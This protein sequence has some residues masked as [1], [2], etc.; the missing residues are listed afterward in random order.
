[1]QHRENIGQHSQQ[2]IPQIQLGTDEFSRDFHLNVWRESHER[3]A[4]EWNPSVRGLN[5][6]VRGLNP[7]VRRLDYPTHL[8]LT[9]SHNVDGTVARYRSLSTSA[10]EQPSLAFRGERGHSLSHPRANPQ[11]HPG[12]SNP[13]PRD[14]RRYSTGHLGSTYNGDSTTGLQ[15]F[16]EVCTYGNYRP[17][18]QSAGGTNAQGLTKLSNTADEYNPVVRNATEAR[19]PQVLNSGHIRT[20][21]YGNEDYNPVVRNAEGTN[22]EVLNAGD[23]QTSTYTTNTSED[24]N[25]VVRGIEGRNL[26]V[27][28]GDNIRK[29]SSLSS[30]TESQVKSIE[31]RRRRAKRQHPPTVVV[32]SDSD[33]EELK[34]LSPLSSDDYDQDVFTVDPSRGSLS[35]NSPN[36]STSES[37]AACIITKVKDPGDKSV[38]LIGKD[39]GVSC[40]SQKDTGPSKTGQES[41]EYDVNNNESRE[42]VERNYQQSREGMG[43][44]HEQCR[45]GNGYRSVL[46]EREIAGQSGTQRVVMSEQ[47][48]FD[49]DKRGTKRTVKDKAQYF[50]AGSAE[51]A[52]SSFDHTAS[53][54]RRISTNDLEECKRRRSDTMDNASHQSSQYNRAN[55]NSGETPKPTRNYEDMP[56]LIRSRSENDEQIAKQML[57]NERS[58]SLTY[59]SR[60]FESKMDDS[61]IKTDVIEQIK[62]YKLSSKNETKSHCK[63]CLDGSICIVRVPEVVTVTKAG[64]V[65]SR[66]EI[67]CRNCDRVL[68]QY[69]SPG[70][71]I[72][73]TAVKLPRSGPKPTGVVV[74]IKQEPEVKQP[75]E[76]ETVGSEN[77]LKKPLQSKVVGLEKELEQL[78]E[79]NTV[80]SEK[81]VKNSGPKFVIHEEDDFIYEDKVSSDK[82]SDDLD[83][84]HFSVVKKDAGV[85]WTNSK[86]HAKNTASLR[87][88]VHPSQQWEAFSLKLEQEQMIKNSC[89]QK[90]FNIKRNSWEELR[91]KFAAEEKMFS[92]GIQH[93]SVACSDISERS[94]A[95]RKRA[96]SCENVPESSHYY[97]S[98]KFHDATEKLSE[99]FKQR[100]VSEKCGSEILASSNLPDRVSESEALASGN[101]AS[102]EE[103]NTATQTQAITT[104]SSYFFTKANTSEVLTTSNSTSIGKDLITVNC[105]TQTALTQGTADNVLKTTTKP[106]A[107]LPKDSGLSHLTKGSRDYHCVEISKSPKKVASAVMNIVGEISNVDSTETV[108]SKAQ[109]FSPSDKKPYEIRLSE[110][111]PIELNTRKFEANTG[112]K[113]PYEIRSSDIRPSEE[114]PFEIHTHGKDP[115]QIRPSDKRPFEVEPA[116]P[117]KETKAPESPQKELSLGEWTEILQGR[118]AQVRESI[119]EETTPWKTKNKKKVLEKLENHLVWLTGPNADNTIFVTKK[120]QF[121]QTMRKQYELMN[122]IKTQRHTMKCSDITS[123]IV[124]NVEK[125]KAK[126]AKEVVV[127]KKTKEVKKKEVK[128]KEAKKKAKCKPKR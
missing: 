3:A 91:K 60:N 115:Y 68:N 80:G 78:L 19:N 118:I 66:D 75:P 31:R 25:P 106:S 117:G 48:L 89:G 34:I 23:F 62:N 100:K 32:I 41:R 22:L 105:T 17:T 13:P 43:M 65:V 46:Y 112:E 12:S 44:S 95:P 15:N 77:E 37:E 94:R 35:S 102:C 56:K 84:L 99:Q 16:P 53:K 103:Q 96:H 69:Y 79:C 59:E 18:L 28:S 104:P 83:V 30:E 64:D 74:G 45:V 113:Y 73:N 42:G 47:M 87:D 27:S 49:K 24:Y 9:S 123:P 119:E 63:V 70:T 88:H 14:M 39:K 126:P 61:I 4:K 10:G 58:K 114:R 67:R 120:L 97:K 6:P 82:V 92:N 5:P 52:G 128:K 121:F 110:E 36:G 85:T 122:K 8:P 2:G 7:P 38:Q 20:S 116:S 124:E 40:A 29:S 57:K 81:S 55:V 1:M 107:N 71:E 21:S 50:V 101:N 90:N 108:P 76:F 93:D 98:Y 26:E 109:E 125:S 11:G 51:L 127:T 86:D 54:I 33:D 72:T 111:T